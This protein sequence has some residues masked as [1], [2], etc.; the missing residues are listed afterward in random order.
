[1][2]CT[3]RSKLFTQQVAVKLFSKQ[4]RLLTEFRNARYITRYIQNARR[5]NQKIYSECKIYSG[6][7]IDYKVVQLCI[8]GDV[9]LLFVKVS[10][11][12]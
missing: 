5:H 2:P 6:C 9:P 11:M 4:S 7:K 12:Q 3:D 8:T 10:T 1:M